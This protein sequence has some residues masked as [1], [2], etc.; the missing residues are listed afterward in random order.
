MYDMRTGAIGRAEVHAVSTTVTELLW[1]VAAVCFIAIIGSLKLF[2]PFDGDQ[3]LF[4]YMAEAID[5]GEILYVDVWD[6]KQP[7]I[8]WFFWMAGKLFGFTTL[9]TKLLELAWMLALA[10]AMIVCLRHYFA[11]PWLAA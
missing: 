7:G 2:A 5:E 8:F 10:A 1:A 6:M 4:L 9:G 3:A 11:H